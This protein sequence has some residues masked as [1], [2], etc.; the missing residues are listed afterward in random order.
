MLNLQQISIR[1]A[2]DQLELDST[3]VVIDTNHA[4]LSELIRHSLCLRKQRCLI[5]SNNL[6]R[7]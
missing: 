5:L 6:D 2:L 7:E 3:N 4:E 1:A